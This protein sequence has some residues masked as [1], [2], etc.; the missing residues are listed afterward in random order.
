MGKTVSQSTIRLLLNLSLINYRSDWFSNATLLDCVIRN[1]SIHKDK[2][3]YKYKTTFSGT[4]T[5]FSIIFTLNTHGSV[6]GGQKHTPK[7]DGT[8][9]ST[10]PFERLT[11]TQLGKKFPMLREIRRFIKVLTKTRHFSLSRVKLI[12]FT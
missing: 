7:I 3:A 4:L 9:W 2:I 8:L 12:Q 5:L 10:V 11:L 6:I 1:R